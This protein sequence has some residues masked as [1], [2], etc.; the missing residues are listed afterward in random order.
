MSLNV[1][2]VLLAL[3]LVNMHFA[4]Q[5]FAEDVRFNLY[6]LLLNTKTMNV[7][8]ADV[9]VFCQKRLVQ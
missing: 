5:L 9:S 4:T 1:T 8:F 3:D 7:T 6:S 2:W